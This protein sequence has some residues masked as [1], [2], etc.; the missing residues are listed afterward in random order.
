MTGEGDW[1]AVRERAS[2]AATARLGDVHSL[3]AASSR[4][5]MRPRPLLRAASTQAVWLSHNRGT[6][7]VSLTTDSETPLVT[8][9]QDDLRRLPV[10]ASALTT[11]SLQGPVTVS[12]IGWPIRSGC[13]KTCASNE[14]A[15]QSLYV[16]GPDTTRMR[17]RR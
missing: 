8:L 2:G 13:G 16:S 15:G 6:V 14:V 11:P 17:R 10:G 4:R 5:P 12:D 7:D 3:I 9:A 1:F